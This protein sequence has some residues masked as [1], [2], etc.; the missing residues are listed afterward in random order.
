MVDHE[1]F[2][3]APITEALLDI[4]VSLPEDSDL[5]SLDLFSEK[6]TE[7]FPIKEPRTLYGGGMEFKGDSPPTY[8]DP[9]VEQVGYIYKSEG[10]NKVAQARLNGFA[11]SILK[12]YDSWSIF[13]D[14]ARNL[15]QLYNDLIRP[16][17]INRIAVRYI[18]RIE[19]P[20]PIEDFRDYILTSPELAPGVPQSIIEFFYRVAVPDSDSKAIAIIMSTIE[21]PKKDQK[22]L[23]YIFDIDAFLTTK[24][25]PGSEEIW[26]MF[27]ALR[28][29]KNRIFF[30]SITEK[31]AELFR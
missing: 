21:R 13:R 8:I 5:S 23:P 9:T 28:N 14:E 4:Q 2:R 17:T 6:M 15:W 11:L 18:N 29:Y 25:D 10:H 30:K 7:E 22:F 12:P 31:T 16:K 27:E 20:L 3:N 19:I 24:L 1:T 26:E